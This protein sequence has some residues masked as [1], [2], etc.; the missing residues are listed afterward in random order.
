[1]GKRKLP[2]AVYTIHVGH[3]DVLVTCRRNEPKCK[4]WHDPGPSVVGHTLS[5]RLYAH[6]GSQ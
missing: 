6:V 2:E 1:M 3:S 4:G 5:L